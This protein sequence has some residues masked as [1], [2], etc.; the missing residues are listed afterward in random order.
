MSIGMGVELREE[1]AVVLPAGR[2]GLRLYAERLA[3]SDPRAQPAVR[4]WRAAG[5]ATLAVLLLSSALQY[6]FFDVY[7]TIMALPRVT[8]VAV[9]SR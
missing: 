4:R 6:Y 8:L 3:A 2:A 7:L 9:A 5:R 1:S